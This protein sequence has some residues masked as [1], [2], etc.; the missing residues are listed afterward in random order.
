MKMRVLWLAGLDSLAV[1]QPQHHQPEVSLTYDTS[2]RALNGTHWTVAVVP[3]VPRPESPLLKTNQFG[4]LQKR[5]K[6]KVDWAGVGVA[7]SLP[8]SIK[9]G[10]RIWDNI[11]TK[12]KGKSD[13]NS[14]TLTWSTAF[15]EQQYLG[16]T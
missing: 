3:T 14:C 9:H 4:P 2:P 13:Q 7:F 1:C 16:Y 11:A 6:I 5:K 8:I 12:I 10:L 15:D